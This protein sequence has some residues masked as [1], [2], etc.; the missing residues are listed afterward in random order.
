MDCTTTMLVSIV[1]F[2]KTLAQDYLNLDDYKEEFDHFLADE[3]YT[4]GFDDVHAQNE[5]EYHDYPSNTDSDRK[6]SKR[7]YS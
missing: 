3:T 5:Y 1:L 6:V 2:S 4:D 7:M